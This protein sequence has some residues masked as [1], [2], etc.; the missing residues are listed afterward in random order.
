MEPGDYYL[1]EGSKHNDG[2]HVYGAGDLIG[3]TLTGHVT[4][5]RI[6]PALL[7]LHEE[8][9]YWQ[10]KNADIVTSPYQSESFAGYS[11][12]K[13]S[14]NTSAGGAEGWQSFFSGRLRAWRKI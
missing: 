9:N 2:V 13:K 12:A 4:E 5:C 10:Q 14:G 1:I 8:I 7:A 3:D 11:Y 6:P